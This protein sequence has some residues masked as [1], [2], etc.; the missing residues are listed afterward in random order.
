[1]KVGGIICVLVA[2]AYSSA[3]GLTSVNTTLLTLLGFFVGFLMFLVTMKT[4]SSAVSTVYVC[5]AERP[6]TFAVSK[7]KLQLWLE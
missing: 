4:I 3:V 5:F 7:C 1:V 6:D 2:Y